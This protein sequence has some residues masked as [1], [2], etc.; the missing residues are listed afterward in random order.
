MRWWVWPVSTYNTVLCL[1]PP[2]QWG[3]FKLTSFPWACHHCG[4]AWSSLWTCVIPLSFSS[5]PAQ[6]PAALSLITQPPLPILAL[7]LLDTWP[8]PPF[9]D[10]GQSVYK[11][12]TQKTNRYAVMKQG[13]SFSH[14]R[15]A[16]VGSELLWWLLHIMRT[17]E[18]LFLIHTGSQGQ[19]TDGVGG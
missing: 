15:N 11:G 5:R 8:C 16:A 13:V 12:K 17:Q 4:D 6:S 9:S 1:G 18:P 10:S 3:D 7:T 2:A 14:R 19:I